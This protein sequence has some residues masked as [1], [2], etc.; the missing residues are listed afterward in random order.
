MGYARHFPR[1]GFANAVREDAPARTQFPS[2]IPGLHKFHPGT[3]LRN[4]SICPVRQ[5]NELHGPETGRTSGSSLYGAARG[6]IHRLIGHGSAIRAAPPTPPEGHHGRGARLRSNVRRRLRP[7]APETAALVNRGRPSGNM[8]STTAVRGTR[9]W[10][11]HRQTE[12]RDSASS[13]PEPGFAQ[14]PQYCGAHHRDV[15]PAGR[16]ISQAQPD[17][18]PSSHLRE[19]LRLLGSGWILRLVGSGG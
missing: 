18:R 12:F 3:R 15:F 4:C 5:H 17:S 2:R 10:E 16:R 6:P 8:G 7:F 11:R 13:I 1:Q 19:V 9:L 14:A